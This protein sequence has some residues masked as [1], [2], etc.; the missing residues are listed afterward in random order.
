MKHLNLFLLAV[1]LGFVTAIP[2]GGSQI[3]AA[4]RAIHGHLRAAWMVVLGSVSSDIM[5]GVIALFGIAPFLDIPW[6]MA[7]FSAVGA[8]VLW[9]LAYMTIRESKKPHHLRL[10]MN[11][12]KSKRWAYVT[13]FSLAVTNPPMILTWLYG[14]ALAKHL[15]LATPLTTQAKAIFIAGGA[16]GLGGYLAGLSLV[17]FRIK[18]FIPLKAIG[19]VYYWLGIGLFVLSFFFVYNFIRIISKMGPAVKL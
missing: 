6:V 15:G 19:K 12:L 5:Y 7:A 13:G 17:M 10:D 11:S 16:L 3:E 18:H 1:G 9:I 4:K 14:V 2:V 8:V